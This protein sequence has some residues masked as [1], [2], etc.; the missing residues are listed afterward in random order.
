MAAYQVPSLQEPVDVTIVRTTQMRD[1]AKVWTK[2]KYALIP[3]AAGEQGK[4]LRDWDLWGPLFF[5]LLLAFTL[6]LSSAG[7]SYSEESST[8]AFSLVFTV[9]WIGA[10]VITL[11]AQL[12]GSSM[13]SPLSSFFQSVCALGYCLVPVILGAVLGLILGSSVMLVRLLCVAGGVMWSV[14]SAFGFMEQLTPEKRWKLTAYPV[15]LFYIFLGWL[16]LIV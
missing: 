14:K 6:S 4:Q 8:M 15:L 9:V 11:N 5:C 10:A 12:L 3:Q 2:V 7:S 16:V 13:Y 1:L